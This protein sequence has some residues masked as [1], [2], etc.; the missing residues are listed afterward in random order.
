MG[1]RQ[2]GSKEERAEDEAKGNG[3][4]DG[5]EEGG[6]TVCKHREVRGET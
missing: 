5:D 6:N 2:G 1:E 3:N 4:E